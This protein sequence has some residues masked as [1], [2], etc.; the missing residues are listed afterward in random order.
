M[1]AYLLKSFFLVRRSWSYEGFK[2]FLRA[3]LHRKSCIYVRTFVLFEAQSSYHVSLSLLNRLILG[4][5]V[6]GGLLKRL[7]RC[8]DATHPPRYGL[9]KHAY[10]AESFVVP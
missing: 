7:T 3:M 8:T 2:G 4:F 5:H 6:F 1:R 10:V 9:E